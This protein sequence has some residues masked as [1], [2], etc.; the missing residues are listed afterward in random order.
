MMGEWR[1]KVA[2]MIDGHVHVRAMASEERLVSFCAGTGTT[3]L[4]LQAIQEPESGIG[5]PQALYLKARHPERCYVFAGLNHAEQ[6]SGGQVRTPGL[7]EQVDAYV[8]MG[9]DGL[10]MLEGKPTSRQQMD[11][12]VTDGYFA[13]YWAHVEALGLPI[14]WHVNDP[15]EF[16]DPEKIP[17][18]AKVR[19]WGYGPEDAQK[20]A[21]YA[22]VEAVLARH[23]RLNI[24]FAHFYF[25][26][27]D[28]ARARRFLDAHPTVC[29]DLAPGIEMQY[30]LSRDPDAARAFF[31]DYADRIVY[32]SDY[33][34]WMTVGEGCARAGTIF[35]WL[36]SDDTFRVPP[37]A[38]F[39][40]GPPEDGLIHGLALPGEVLAKI[41]AGN[42]TRLAGPAPRPLQ[43]NAAR[44]ECARQAAVT[45]AMSG[46][47]AGAEAA[48]IGEALGG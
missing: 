48:R 36:E 14:T 28:L 13:D 39:L 15:E 38:D 2:E 37:T 44:E 46:T 42:F 24:I 19:N 40:F 33:A 34:D 10:K 47:P 29:L 20:E 18:W 41:Y 30:N 45:A 27:A 32:G 43:L 11:I 31:L 8:A 22:E 1:S 6:L 4:V 17:A 25:L 12:P 5:L 21:L 3:R 26:S 16:W 7:V 9:C 23:P 35:R